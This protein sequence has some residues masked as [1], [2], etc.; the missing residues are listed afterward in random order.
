MFL[1]NSLDFVQ[2]MRS[3]AIIGCQSNRVKPE[4]G[5]ISLSFNM[6]VW[7]FIVFV[8]EKEKAIPADA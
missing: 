4:F 1:N 6:D 2:F 3:E 8:A 7:R 5:L